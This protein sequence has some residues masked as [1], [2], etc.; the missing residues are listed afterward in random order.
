[1]YIKDTEVDVEEQLNI[2]NIPIATRRGSWADCLCPFHEEGTP[3]FS[4]NLEHGGWID[5]H[6]ATS[7]N[8]VTLFM[9]ITELSRRDAINYL[10]RNQP[11]PIYTD[12][13]LL[14][15]LLKR[16]PETAAVDLNSWLNYYQML[17]TDILPMWWFQRGF[18]WLEAERF[19][20]RY[21]DKNDCLTF[22]VFDDMMNIVGYIERRFNTKTKYKYPKGWNRTLYPVNEIEGTSVVLVEGALDAMTLLKYG[23]P[24][25]AILGS[26]ITKSQE[27]YIRSHYNKIVIMLDNDSAGL[28]G[29]LTLGR[30]L[31]DLDAAIAYL[32]DGIKD[33]NEATREQLVDC[34]TNCVSAIV[35]EEGAL[36]L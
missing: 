22:P 13:M 3:S 26:S 17:S 28:Q 7:G 10:V 24:A 34:L 8:F 12:T 21:D 35:V 18:T 23:I 31:G 15:L 30:K 27:D 6:D 25:V 2:L 14:D 33:P 19:G 5:R 20:V 9:R 36:V 4:I 1:M 11:A 32:P 29:T 16:Q